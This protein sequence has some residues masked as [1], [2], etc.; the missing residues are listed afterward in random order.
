LWAVTSMHTFL[1]D[2]MSLRSHRYGAPQL[3]LTVCEE[4]RASNCARRR[5][6]CASHLISAEEEHFPRYLKAKIIPVSWVHISH[7][8]IKSLHSSINEMSSEPTVAPYGTWK[9]SISIDQVT[10]SSL[11]FDELYVNV[12]KFPSPKLY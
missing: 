5:N 1:L 7:I 11:S 4:A 12:S 3:L 9:S 10:E 2:W 6:L 8:F